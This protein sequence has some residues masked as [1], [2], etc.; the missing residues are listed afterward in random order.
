MKATRNLTL[1]LVIMVLSCSIRAYA[2]LASTTFQEAYQNGACA[3]IEFLCGDC[4]E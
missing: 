1:G 3:K 2:L 4:H